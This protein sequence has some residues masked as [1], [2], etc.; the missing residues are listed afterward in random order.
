VVLRDLHLP[1]YDSHKFPQQFIHFVDLPFHRPD[2]RPT[3]AITAQNAHLA[4]AACQDCQ[5][6]ECMLRCP[7]G[8]DIP[9]FL[10]RMEA[11]NYA[12]AARLIREKNP[13]GETCGITCAA[14]QLCQQ[15]CTRREFASAPVRI[16]ELQGWVCAEAGET[17]W[18]KPLRPASGTPVTVIGGGPSAL[19]CAYYLALAGRQVTVF[20]PEDQPGSKLWAK[21]TSDPLLKAAVARDIQAVMSS[22]IT[23]HGGQSTGNTLDLDNLLE[24]VAAV[25]LPE[26]RPEDSNGA[27]PAWRTNDWRELLDSQT[28]QVP[29]H[30]GVFIGQEFLMNGVTVVAAAASGRT[31]A[32]AINQFLIARGK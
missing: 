24:N 16:A 27:N 4:A 15:N 21:S 23:F 30:P 22:R 11:K 3:D 7:A 26:P 6:P 5:V 29:G 17:G 8:I 18:L 10:R 13:F 32:M 1:E 20:A 9:G 14:D 31:A 2:Y 12:G 28:H 25:Y 19:S